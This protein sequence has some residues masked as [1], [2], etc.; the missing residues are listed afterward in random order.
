[1]KITKYGQ[2]A[3]LIENYKNKRILIDPGSYC[4]NGFKPEDFGQVD[5]LLITHVHQDHCVPEAIKVIKENSSELIIL[6]NKE[7][8]NL[9]KESG[10]D[11]DAMN[12]GEVRR[13]GGVEIKCIKQQHGDTSVFG[14]PT[15]D[16]VGFL[17]DDKLYHTGD[18]VYVKEKPYAEVLFVPICGTVVMDPK[19]AAKFA[20]EQGAKLVIPIHYDNPKFQVDVNDF[21][22]AAHG[23]NVRVLKFGESVDVQ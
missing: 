13:I 1:M 2:S 15:P 21:V 9:L 12:P 23:L 6:S 22:K 7:V 17:I 5:I 16:D 11:C 8:K 14:F 10:L 4:Y 20:K 18:T 3:V 19:T